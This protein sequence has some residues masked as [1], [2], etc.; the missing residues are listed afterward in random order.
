MCY[1]A[2]ISKQQRWFNTVTNEDQ[3][4]TGIIEIDESFID[5]EVCQD[6]TIDSE[7]D[8]VDCGDP[9]VRINN[10]FVSKE[11]RGQG[12][13]KR[14]IELAVTAIKGECD[15]KIKIVAEPKES[16]VDAEKLASF[17]DRYDMEVVAY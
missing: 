16:C 17:Y 1:I 6:T 9:Y 2:I 11:S 8:E 10:L 4:K 5:W 13:A 7:G 15:L 12:L 3:M 14:L